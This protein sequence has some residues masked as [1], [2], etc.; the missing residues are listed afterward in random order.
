MMR[1][2]LNVL[3]HA[4]DGT[5]LSTLIFHRVLPRSDPLFPGEIDAQKFDEICGWV[6]NWFNVLALDE[7]LVRLKRGDLPPRALA[8]TFDDGYADNHDI[9]LPI[10]RR[11]RL[12][13]TFYVATGFLDGGRM[14]NDS[15][16]ESIRS[17]PLSIIDLL[18]TPAAEL[19]QLM[20]GDLPSRRQAINRTI[21]SIKYRSMDERMDFVNAVVERSQANLPTDLMMTSAQ[22]KALHSAGMQVG[23]H[24]VSHPILAKLTRHAA[25]Q[26]IA[27]SKHVLEA[28]LGIRVGQFAYPNGKPG[29]DYSA[30]SVEIVK[31]LGFDAAVSTVWGTAGQ[32]SDVF[33][34]P[35]FTPWDRTRWRFG[36][37]LLQ[38]L[39]RK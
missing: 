21:S 32:S 19:G 13:A 17:S 29:E 22:V 16:I 38:N 30:E 15:I 1:A 23:A 5:R 2:L 26:E 6:E 10:L 9:A 4:G 28:I 24:T 14:W 12:C 7:A 36:A 33:Q 11:H 20:I 39:R 31:K 25:E 8:I 34:V 18:G 27:Q 3:S 35:R 37:R